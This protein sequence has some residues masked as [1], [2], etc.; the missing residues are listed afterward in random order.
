[1]KLNDF[2]MQMRKRAFELRPEN[3]E[4]SLQNNEQIY[5]SVA[6]LNVND[7][8]VTLICTI[9]GTVSLYYSSGKYDI[10]L[11]KNEDVR[12]AAISLLISSGQ[13]IKSMQRVDKYPVETKNIQV[14]LFSKDGIYQKIITSDEN[15]TKEEKFLNFLIQNVLT[16]IRMSKS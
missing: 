16:S 7:S 3:M 11:G 15:Q 9:D 6:D 14:F 4:I 10:G 1:M 13:C 5:A 8:I 12:Q 2:Y